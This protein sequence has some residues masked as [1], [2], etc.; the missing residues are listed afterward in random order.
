MAAQEGW[1]YGFGFGQ[2][3]IFGGSTSGSSACYVRGWNRAAQYPDGFFLMD[4]VHEHGTV[5]W[6]K[7]WQELHQK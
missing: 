5:V 2:I 7:V 3:W 1:K 6:I 4:V